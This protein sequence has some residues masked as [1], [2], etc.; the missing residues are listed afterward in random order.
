MTVREL[1][2]KLSVMSPDNVIY[3]AERVEPD[4]DRSDEDS[5]NGNGFRFSYTDEIVLINSA[6]AVI[7]SSNHGRLLVPS[8]EELMRQ[9]EFYARLDAARAAEP[10]QPDRY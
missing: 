2:E 8:E 4:H 1:I 5:L 10:A 3:S 7:I 9:K 6:A